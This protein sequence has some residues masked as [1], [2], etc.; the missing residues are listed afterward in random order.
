MPKLLC[1]SIEG[2][3]KVS[4]NR[5]YIRITDKSYIRECNNIIKNAVK[6][7]K[8]NTPI[9]LFDSRERQNYRLSRDAWCNEDEEFIHILKEKFGENNIR[10]M[11]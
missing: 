10:I 2:L 1:E 9:Y 8:G 7:Y 5:I 4:S 6:N 11:N 3:E